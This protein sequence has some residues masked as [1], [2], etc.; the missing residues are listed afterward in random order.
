MGIICS[1]IIVS[2]SRHIVTDFTPDLSPTLFEVDLFHSDGSKIIETEAAQTARSKLFYQQEKEKADDNKN[3]KLES[4][5]LMLWIKQSL[6]PAIKIGMKARKEEWSVIITTTDFVKAIDYLRKYSEKSLSSDGTE[7]KS[8]YDQ[9]KDMRLSGE[10]SRWSAFI[11]RYQILMEILDV[12]NSN[13][14][15][16]MPDMAT[17]WLRASVNPGYRSFQSVLEHKKYRGDEGTLKPRELLY[18]LNK[19]YEDFPL[20]CDL[21]SD[22]RLLEESGSFKKGAK[23]DAV[24]ANAAKA[25][26]TEPTKKEKAAAKAKTETKKAE[27]ELNDWVCKF[28][29]CAL[30]GKWHAKGGHE[31][32]PSTKKCQMC[33]E[34]GHAAKECPSYDCKKKASA[35]VSFVALMDEAVMESD[36]DDDDY[37]EESIIAKTVVCDDCHDY[38][39]GPEGNECD[40]CVSCDCK[41]Q[42]VFILDSGCIGGSVVNDVALLSEVRVTKG[43]LELGDGHTIESTEV[44]R[45]LCID[46]V[47]VNTA[48]PGNLLS[49][50][51]LC[52]QHKL[53]IIEDGVTMAIHRK[54]DNKCLTTVKFVKGHGYIVSLQQ[55]CVLSKMLDP[56][57]CVKI[58]Y[59]TVYTPQQRQRSWEVFKGH[60]TWG[61]HASDMILGKMLDDGLIAGCDYTAKD[62][63]IARVLFGPCP[64]C[65]EGKIREDPEPASDTPPHTEVGGNVAMDVF[66]LGSVTIG[67]NKAGFLSADE[68]SGLV[69]F[70][71]APNKSVTHVM[72][73]IGATVAYYNG[74][75]HKVQM[76]TTDHENCFLAA[77]DFVRSLGIQ[78]SDTI[79]GR[80]QKL[81]ERYKQTLDGLKRTVLAS[82]S[83]VPPSKLDGELYS[84]CVDMMNATVNTKSSPHTPYFL[85]TGKK[86][87]MRQFAW[88][89]VGIFVDP[90]GNRE[91]RWGMIVGFNPDTTYQ[92][93]VYFPDLDRVL[94]RRS[95]KPMDDVPV[96]WGWPKRIITAAQRRTYERISRGTY[97]P[98]NIVVQTGESISSVVPAQLTATA[99][100][101]NSSDD[102]MEEEGPQLV[103]SPIGVT[104][105][106][107]LHSEL[108]QEVISADIGPIVSE[109]V[110]EVEQHVWQDDSANLE[111]VVV[112]AP[113]VVTTKPVD[114]AVVS[115]TSRY[116]LRARKSVDYNLLSR[117]SFVKLNRTSVKAALKGDQR[118]ETMEAIRLE[119]RAM[120]ETHRAL[121]AVKESD[122]P[123]DKRRQVIRAH[124]FMKDKF[125]PD[126]SFDKKKARMVMGGDRQAPET[127]DDTSSPT[128][129]P[130]SI[131]TI[132]NLMAIE[133]FEAEVHDVPSAFLIPDMDPGDADMWVELDRVMTA[134]LVD[135]YPDMVKYLSHRNTIFM[136]LHK[137]VYGL[138]QASLK[139]YEFM[140]KFFLDIGFV[141]CSGDPCVFIRAS[142][143]GQVTCAIHVDDVLAV[144]TDQSL[145]K[146][147]SDQLQEKLKTT[148]GCGNTLS[149][150][151]MVVKR[152]RLNR[153]ARV[154]M[155]GY[156]HDVIERFGADLKPADSPATANL[157]EVSGDSV[158]VDTNK[159]ASL[160]MT[161]MYL[162]RF[163]RPD[164]LLAVSA[165]ATKMKSP[166]RQDLK[167]LLRIVRYLKRTPDV[168][169]N[170]QPVAGG[171]TV[172]LYVDASHAV[173]PDGKGQGAIV[174]TMGSAPLMSKTWKLKHVTLSSTEAELSALSEAGTYV[175]WARAFMAEL[176]YEQGVPTTVFEDNKSAITMSN[177]GGGSFKR[178]K[179]ITVRNEYVKELVDS[180]QLQ[181]QYCPTT[182]MVADLLTKPLDKTRIKHL[183]E[184]ASVY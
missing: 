11:G 121:V 48:M 13:P 26:E 10:Y 126:G 140:K 113:M 28:K 20:H 90:H 172:R 173:Y 29:G 61:N 145:M 148:K 123:S 53:Y 128:V 100:P 8:A 12:R 102:F 9:L 21:E 120:I 45:L 155:D 17:K 95:M 40:C 36:D 22:K 146:W 107:E 160:L 93:R 103:E 67:G 62:L 35:R 152:D 46:H 91:S 14:F 153:M 157:F 122:I 16:K 98:S 137:Y 150:L 82:L 73:A 110:Q 30:F 52:Q 84:T 165:L 119:L 7:G 125:K 43:S 105:S 142:R 55:L 31:Y 6:S 64:A 180:E 18:D 170:F 77:H 131:M 94:S 147:I 97:Y 49:T 101:T 83:F 74:Y 161:L 2:K 71:P 19:F 81:V 138:K 59:T 156:T 86:P 124:C 70:V 179:H 129:N 41:E 51:Q 32:L 109:P 175:V 24:K 96:D 176:G 139:F 177:Q 168:G 4:A 136:K 149:F 174:L 135:M 23:S 34:R 38:T 132:L 159:F 111:P 144:A 108:Q 79:P 183:L 66:D 75:Q 130:I 25:T 134:I 167:K 181:L 37:D 112:D 143:D 184:L 154:T 80:H 54:Q 127:Y 116:N 5:D 158:A 115:E 85:F 42:P 89:Q 162:A 87:K 118:E 27:E 99:V 106:V 76:L 78:P 39:T 164:I 104:Q 65:V 141:Q 47:F 117:G 69:C 178:S 114:S 33:D 50:S 1:L 92:Y 133:D 88:G 63:R 166:D 182:D 58:A 68:A 44:G 169:L 163:T 60:S 3:Y 151:G 56:M 15:D 72:S 57:V 171:P